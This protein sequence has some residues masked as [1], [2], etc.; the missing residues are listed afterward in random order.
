[1]VRPGAPWASSCA[2]TR[3]HSPNT[4]TRGSHSA[5]AR[6]LLAARVPFNQRIGYC[7]SVSARDGS[8]TLRRTECVCRACSPVSCSTTNA[9]GASRLC[10]S[11]ALVVA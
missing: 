9:S 11:S 1:M 4:S 3:C 7:R 6:A 8:N 10:C 5:K 2:E